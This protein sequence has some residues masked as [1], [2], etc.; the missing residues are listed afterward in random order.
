MS[1]DPLDDLPA[2]SYESDVFVNTTATLVDGWERATRQE[3]LDRRGA[4]DRI[5][6]IVRRKEARKYVLLLMI[7]MA[8][9]VGVTRLFLE[10]TG[11]PQVAGGELHIAHLLWGGLL[12]FLAALM[13]LILSNRW[14]YSI[15]AILTGL[16]IGLFLDEVGKFITRTNDYFYPPAAPIIYVIFLLTLWLYLRLRQP[17]PQEPRAVMY[18]V[19]E[20]LS[21]VLDGDLDTDE[22]A[23]LLA[24]L[25]FVQENAR[26]AD[27]ARLSGALREFLGSDELHTIAPPETWS[28]RLGRWA[29]SIAARYVSSRVTRLLLAVLLLLLA[30]AAFANVAWHVVGAFD[31][32]GWAAPADR[33]LLHG[34]AATTGR[35]PLVT[36]WILLEGIAGML[37]L[38]AAGLLAFG[39]VHGGMRL[40]WFTLLFC[41]VVVDVFAFYYLQFLAI[42]LVALQFLALW[43]VRYSRRRQSP[44]EIKDN[45]GKGHA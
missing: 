6:A 21:E 29:H 41:L 15:A 16:G 35:D 12:I 4:G 5:R 23:D 9:A 7:G 20:D 11:Y 43:G 22:R 24:R 10:L 34:V 32:S 31:S 42:V 25:A 18:R 2:V 33:D 8:V 19:L 44:P 30:C 17:A 39:R 37:L 13:T 38:V 45:G 1:N 28:V 36:A 3:R 26:E 40:G 14:A 27:L